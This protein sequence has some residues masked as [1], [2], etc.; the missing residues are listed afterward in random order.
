MHK[1]NGLSFS[2][3]TVN[4]GFWKDR[5]SVNENVT[6]KCVQDQFE[7]TGRFEAFRF[8]WKEGADVPKPH[9]FWDSDV[10]K[11]IESVAYI[12]SKRDVP[13]LRSKVEELITLI[14]MNQLEDGYF[15]IF[16]TVVQPEN[17]FKIRD[18]HELYCLGH[19]IEAAVAWDNAVR[20]DRLIKVFDRYID[21]VIKVFVT[22]KSAGFTTPG[23]EEIELAL[24]KLFRHTNNTKYLDLALFFLNNRGISDESYASYYNLSQIQSHLA[25]RDQKEA[26]GHAVRACYLYSAMADAAKET[27]DYE[28]FNTCKELFK[29]ITER[30]MYISGGIGSSHHGEA[31]TTEYD[32]PNDSAYAETCASI[33]LMMFADRMKDLQIDS[34]YADTVERTIYNGILSGV[35]LK[36]NAFFYENPLEINL[37]DRNRHTSIKNIP[38]RLPIVE[39]QEVFSCSCCPPNL[40]RFFASIADHSYSYNENEVFIHQFI[41]SEAEFDSFYLKAETSY[42]ENGRLHVV[43]RGA[44]GKKLYVRIPFWCRNFVSD[45]EY[46]NIN[47]YAMYIVDTDEFELVIDMQMNVSLYCANPAV[48]ADAGKVAVMYGP[49]LYC[50]ES[51]DNDFNLFD[52]IIQKN[53]EFFCRYDDFFKAH[54]IEVEVL[55]SEKMSS[56]YF[57]PDELNKKR[58][59]LKLIPY[60][61]FANRGQSDMRVWFRYEI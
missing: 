34:V 7:K 59:T 33:A 9:I 25:V 28:L 61:A 56:L 35:S 8:N 41:N 6:I 1:S 54:V 45:K 48:R 16:H 49:I 32:L 53:S 39:R 42:P 27:D 50:A 21:L 5:M 12:L 20:S 14:E 38:V 13:E 31:F 52:V 51:I 58:C 11:W 10:A 17:R 47:G 60:H 57:S 46:E 26:M 55:I 18:N 36:G 19:F 43:L 22:E 37:S 15:N 23:H 24:I 44:A 2:S 4:D 29:D 40:T 3:V 30:K